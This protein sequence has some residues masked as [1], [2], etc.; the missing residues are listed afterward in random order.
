MLKNSVKKKQNLQ[1][2]KFHVGEKWRIFGKVTKIFPDEYFYS[3]NII[4]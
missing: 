1:D 3:T 2:E 4:K